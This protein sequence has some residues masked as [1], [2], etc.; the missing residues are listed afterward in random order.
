MT[1][2]VATPL[3]R[4]APFGVPTMWLYLP[5][6]SRRSDGGTNADLPAVLR[7]PAGET[8]EML[9]DTKDGPIAA[10]SS[11]IMEY[12]RARSGRARDRKLRNH[13]RE[14]SVQ[15]VGR[16]FHYGPKHFENL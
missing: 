6:L 3:A 14:A 5:A 15:L 4:Y 8:G 10:Q 16:E 13:S 2:K 9:V 11:S 1:A 12:G 7:K